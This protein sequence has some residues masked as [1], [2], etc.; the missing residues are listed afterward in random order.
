MT[1]NHDVFGGMIVFCEVVDSDGFATAARKLGHSASHVS[2]EIARLEDRLG[3][4][5]L[6][7]TTRTMSLT[8]IGQLYY[9]HVRQIIDDARETESKILGGKNIPIGSLRVS[10][11]VS[12]GLS[13]LAEALPEFLHDNPQMA[14]DMEFNDR[15]VDVIAEGY[16][17]VLRIGQLKD[18]SLIAR[19][20]G[21]TRGVTVASPDYWKVHGKPR[22]PKNL[23]SH[24]AISYALMSNPARW[25]YIDE[26]G[27]PLAV[28]MNVRVKCNSAELETILATRG[29]GVTRLPEFVC[30]KELADG[31][32]EP[33]LEEFVGPSIGIYAVYPHRRHLSPK[34]RVFI[35]FLVAK[36]GKD[37]DRANAR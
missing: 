26:N 10:V 2:K 34:V 22:H 13:H 35:D 11:P 6:N 28:N 20:I 8:E 3:A 23:E 32:L 18:T 1:I 36:F 21:V 19:Q 15:M 4:R 24:T 5:L 31:L 12:F 9:E 33:V 37:L 27:E 30:A 29:V 25:E 7:R 16:D 17:V 14:L